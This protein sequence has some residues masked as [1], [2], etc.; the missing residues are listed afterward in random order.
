MRRCPRPADRDARRR[1]LIAPAAIGAE[2]ALARIED[3]FG[4]VQPPRRQ[5]QTFERFRRFLDREQA[6]EDLLCLLPR[7]GLEGRATGPQIVNRLRSAHN[8]IISSGTSRIDLAQEGGEQL[9]ELV[10]LLH[11]QEV[12]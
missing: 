6:F 7:A 12:R 8:R 1:R 5:A 2:R 9:I 11:H 10:R 4:Q 3:D